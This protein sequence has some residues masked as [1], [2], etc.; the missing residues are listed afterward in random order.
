MSGSSW[1]ETA[2]IRRLRILKGC[3]SLSTA[4]PASN[5][6]ARVSN[7]SSHL[8]EARCACDTGRP[9]TLINQLAKIL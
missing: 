7:S 3:K 8:A 1:V 6:D 2:S 5:Q 4:S 9:R